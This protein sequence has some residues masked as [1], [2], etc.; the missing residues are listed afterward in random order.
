MF[1]AVMGSRSSAIKQSLEE[2]LKTELTP[3]GMTVCKKTGRLIP[4]EEQQQQETKAAAFAAGQVLKQKK[5]SGLKPIEERSRRYKTVEEFLE[6]SAAKNERY[7]D[8][9][10]FRNGMVNQAC[11]HLQGGKAKAKDRLDQIRRRRE[12]LRAERKSSKKSNSSS[13]SEEPA[14]VGSRGWPCYW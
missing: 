5:E 1:D 13:S 6:S 14:K 9:N 8:L 7:V 12:R 4:V 10:A 11:K 2:L 3:E